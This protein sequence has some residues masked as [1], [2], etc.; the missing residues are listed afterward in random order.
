[1]GEL[2]QE[3][4]VGNIEDV[5]AIAGDLKQNLQKITQHG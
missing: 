4:E 1:V 3:A 5:K 2:E